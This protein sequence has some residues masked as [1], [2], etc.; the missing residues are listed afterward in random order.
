MGFEGE[1]GK[2]LN[3]PQVRTWGGLPVAHHLDFQELIA[4]LLRSVVSQISV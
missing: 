2:P 3:I 4:E 1:A